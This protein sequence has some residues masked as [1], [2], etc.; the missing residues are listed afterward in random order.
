MILAVNT[1]HSTIITIEFQDV[2]DKVKGPGFWNLNCSLLNDKK[3]VPE[4]NFLLP[5]WL[6]EGE[7]QLSDPYS[8]WD[9]VK[10]NVKK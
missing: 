4:I 9:W 6:Q 10:Y 1:D 5:S 3:Y 2:A 7:R 8:V